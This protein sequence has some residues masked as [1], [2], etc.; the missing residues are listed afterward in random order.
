MLMSAATP[1]SRR[2]RDGERF[3]LA[4]LALGSPAIAEIAVA[5]GADGLVLDLQHGLFDRAGLEAAV[6]ASGAA[7]AIVRVAENG[8]TAI[9][10]ALD[11][12]A[13][14]VLVPLVESA[15]EAAAAVAHARFPPHGRRS[16]GGVRP[17]SAGFPA[18]LARAAETTVGVMIET[19]AGVE[20][21]EAIAAVPGL[22]FVLV[23]TGD[24]RLSYADRADPDA[25]R[26]AGCARVLAACRAA[27]LPAGIFTTTAADAAARRAAGWA[28]TVAANDID[29]V[30]AGFRSSVAALR[31]TGA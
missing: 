10:T 23:G 5:A 22:D 24:L 2:L 11:A 25:A 18:Y 13:D 31:E 30:A 6:A 12:G 27:G 15:A 9:S 17:L 7:P 1:F 4:W 21:A 28:L 3:A 8:A 26:E 29:A 20:A 14:G 19:A 16:G